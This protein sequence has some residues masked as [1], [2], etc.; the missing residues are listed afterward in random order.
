MK[1]AF[2]IAVGVLVLAA[3]LDLRIGIRGHD[4]PLP[5]EVMKAGVE[6]MR[7]QL[8][9]GDVLVHSPLFG[10]REVAAFGE[11]QV[12][13]DLP[14][15]AIRAS[16]RVLL[17]DRADHPMYG[18]ST[19][20]ETIAL[21]DPLVLKIWKPSGDAQVPMFELLTG[22]DPTSMR[23]ERPE[24]RVSAVC[25]RPRAE[26]GFECP[27]EAEWLYAAPRTLRIGGRDVEC[28]WAHPTTGGV[29]VFSIPAAIAPGPGR[30]L[31]LEVEGGITD[32]A[33]T[34]TPD[35]AP[36]AFDIR[37]NGASIGRLN[38]PN[39]VGFHKAAMKIAPDQPIE[40]RI[41]TL[42]DGRRHQCINARVLEVGG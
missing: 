10:V 33:V 37:Q 14:V 7:A 22:L 1:L 6:A 5:P 11:L 15:P 40:L 34:T 38:V 36:V 3:L 29:I 4:D 26:G 24:G 9:V 13:P 27:G 32:E 16:R 25:N 35:G 39:K 19:P 20:D 28:V 23:V 2:S 8:Q 41:T 30:H 31:E 17:L 42:R 21:P 12:R 18:F